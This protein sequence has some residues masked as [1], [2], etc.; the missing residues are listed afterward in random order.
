MARQFKQ[1]DNYT[2]Q[3]GEEI[4]E[5]EYMEGGE[6]KPIPVKTFLFVG[7][8]VAILIGIAVGASFFV[9]RGN[10]EPADPDPGFGDESGDVQ[11]GGLD[12]DSMF[13]EIPPFAY[14]PEEIEQLRA[15]GYVA[16]EIEENEIMEVPASE[17]IKASKDAQEKAREELNNPE[18]DAYK[19]LMNQTWLGQDI[20]E[21]PAYY[22]EMQMDLYYTSQTLNADYEKVDPHGTNLFLKVY[23]PNGDYHFMECP[24]ARYVQLPDS[25][26]IVVTYQL[27]TLDNYSIIADM[28]EKDVG[29]R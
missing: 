9:N 15:W 3:D 22:P 11:M 5:Q 7:I 2:G 25:G 17:L 27:I 29:D 1:T 26:N 24:L 28:K 20:H 4:E 14:T 13:E 21:P 23:L 10:K 8:G 6:K 16:S 12:L 19:A 18:S